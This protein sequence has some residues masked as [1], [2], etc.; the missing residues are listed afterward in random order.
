VIDV[1]L[2]A[3]DG[4]IVLSVRDK[5]KGL[6]EDFDMKVASRHSLGMRMITSLAR[7][8]RGEVRFDDA[9]PGTCATLTMP[10]PRD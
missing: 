7:Q 10:D 8:L 9:A 1:C 3:R 6:P 5:G 2:H 4:Q